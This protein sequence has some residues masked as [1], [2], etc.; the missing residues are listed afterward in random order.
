MKK[1]FPALCKDCKYSRPEDERSHYNV[2][3]H[4]KVMSDD[5]YTLASNFINKPHGSSCRDEREKK[6][7]AKCGM[8]GKLWESRGL[9]P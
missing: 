6:L 2:C 4:P 7:F 3:T 5:S 9:L 8:K 1:P